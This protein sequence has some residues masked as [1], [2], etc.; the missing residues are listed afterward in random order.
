MEG[1][2]Q[3]VFCLRSS[4][5]GAVHS[6]CLHAIGQN[7]VTQLQPSFRADWG[8]VFRVSR[9]GYSIRWAL[10]ISLSLVRHKMQLFVQM[11]PSHKPRCLGH[12]LWVQGLLSLQLLQ[13]VL[14]SGDHNGPPE[15]SLFGPNKEFGQM[16]NSVTVPSSL[17]PSFLSLLPSSVSN[18]EP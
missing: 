5:R 2:T 8:T 9:K 12:H 18:K 1:D 10:A 4:P 11:R 3:G 15:G 17:P 7:S 13:A 6:S 14:V 16:V